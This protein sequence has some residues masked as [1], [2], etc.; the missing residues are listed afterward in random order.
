MSAPTI[1]P[2]KIDTLMALIGGLQNRVAVLEREFAKTLR[3]LNQL[4]REKRDG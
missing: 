2:R 4:K 3:E 1:D